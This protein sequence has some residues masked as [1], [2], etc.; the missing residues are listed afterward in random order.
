VFTDAS[1]K[2]W[3]I[4]C[5]E[6]IIQGKWL[7]VT[8]HINWLELRVVLTAL[9]MLTQPLMNKSVLFML[10]NTSAVAYLNRQGGTR[11]KALLKLVTRI[12]LQAHAMGV[13]IH[14]R[15]IAG[16]ANVLADLAS[17]AGQIIPSEWT[18]SQRAFNWL[19]QTSPFGR[20][21]IELFAHRLN[22]HLARYISPCQDQAAWGINALSCSLPQDLVWYA[23][24][25]NH[26][27]LPFLK[28]LQTLP[29]FKVLLVVQWSDLAK[30][31]PIVN[32]LHVLQSCEFPL[33]HG[34]L[35]QPHW[36]YETQQAASLNLRLLCLQKLA[37]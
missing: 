28:R 24:P 31:V 13:V 15:H 1:L 18:L 27:V 21:Q 29:Q 4:V 23:F 36:E 19:V 22:H 8:Q 16:E 12:H 14:A 3:G 37:S 9:Q 30:W 7:T 20:P 26:L 34:L 32:A 11:S 17:R 10:D 33:W 25:P 5:G 35:R 2:G 6:Q